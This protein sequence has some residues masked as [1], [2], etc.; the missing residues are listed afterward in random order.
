MIPVL[1]V[2]AVV[3]LLLLLLVVVEPLVVVVDQLLVVAQVLEPHHRARAAIHHEVGPLVD[4][5]YVVERRLGHDE[6]ERQKPDECQTEQRQGIISYK[7]AKF[8][9]IYL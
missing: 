6:E 2:V 4:E 7:I 5:R 8:F 9:H 3:L 1:E